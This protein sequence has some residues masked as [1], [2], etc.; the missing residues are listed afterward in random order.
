MNFARLTAE[1][2][3]SGY[4]SLRYIRRGDTSTFEVNRARLTI[5]A[6][7][8]AYVAIK[9]MGDF[10][11][12]GRTNVDTVPSFLLADAYVQFQLPDTTGLVSILRPTLL[13]GQFKTPFALDYLTSFSAVVTANRAIATDRLASRRDIG[14]LGTF[15]V[16][17]YATFWGAMVNGEG[18]NRP[19]N[20]DG[21][22]LF[23]GRLTAFP[24]Q[25]L[26]VSAKWLGNG[27]DHRWGYDVRWSSP[28][29]ILEGEIIQRS[30]P[31]TNTAA[32]EA[33][34]GYALAAAKP[35]TWLQPL[36]K[37]ER[38]NQ[39]N[40]TP[41][42][43]TQTRAT[44]VTYGVNFLAPRDRVRLQF[45]WIDRSER[46]TPRKDELVIQLQASF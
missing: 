14:L 19:A 8:T 15:S 21:A 30:V 7:P 37:W 40:T 29:V 2:A 43:T 18:Q 10:A 22:Q 33:G 28:R 26:G 5:Q 35:L 24:L 39:T 6:L 45:N 44:W 32:V 17:Q 1:P 41:T 27:L 42:T 13:V 25:T 38:L 3:L 12:I 11:T 46:P 4:G 20:P 9:L 31:R 23:V 34:G 36:V 16:G